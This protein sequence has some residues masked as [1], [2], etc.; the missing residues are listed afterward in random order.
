M[1]EWNPDDASG[2]LHGLAFAKH[3]GW[4]MHSLHT[5]VQSARVI[6]LAVLLFLTPLTA[7]T[8]QTT[9]DFDATVWKSQ[10]GVGLEEN[11]RIYMTEALEQVIHVGMRRED[12][13]ALLGQPDY[14]EKG[15]T[16]STDAY[17]LGISPF[18]GDTQEYDIQYQDG[19]VISRHTVQG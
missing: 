17:Y 6:A 11:K 10:R 13:I 9:Q 14:T 16:T 3:L 18:A 12:V 2:N 1:R 5:H 7:C 4:K 8:M 15:E 19:K